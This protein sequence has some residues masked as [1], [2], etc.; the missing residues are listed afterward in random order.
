MHS[1]VDDWPHW[2]ELYEAEE[3][4]RDYVYKWSRCRLQS[5]EKWGSI[6]YEHVWPPG[7]RNHRLSIKLPWKKTIKWEGWECKADCYLFDW[8]SSRL[9][10]QWMRF[11]DWVLGIAVRKACIKFPNVVKEITCNLDWR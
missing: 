8:P 9:F 6:R 5:K 4:I 3:Y 11:G 10:Y 2:Q 7:F 1:W